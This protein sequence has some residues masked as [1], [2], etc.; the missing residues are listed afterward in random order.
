MDGHYEPIKTHSRISGEWSVADI[1]GDIDGRTPGLP[2]DDVE[3]PD[4]LLLGD[5]V[6]KLSW[7]IYFDYRRALRLTALVFSSKKSVSEH[8]THQ[9]FSLKTAAGKLA[10][11]STV[12]GHSR[13]SVLLALVVDSRS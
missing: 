7:S 4:R 6:E 2:A 12:S 9:K 11:F 5:T 3:W 1:L 8:R 10:T 13:H